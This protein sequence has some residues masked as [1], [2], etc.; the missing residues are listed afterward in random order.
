MRPE[1][2]LLC[3]SDG[4]MRRALALPFS[5]FLA[6]LSLPGCGS[7]SATSVNV[8]G[9]SNSRCQASVSAQPSTFAPAG[10]TGE[11]TVTV[12]RECTWTAASNAGWIE[13]TA[14]REGQGEGTVRYRIAENGEPVTRRG[15]LVVAEQ[16]VQVAQEPAP[17]RFDVSPRETRTGADGGEVSVS[18][19]THSAC[20]WRVS[21][22]SAWASASPQSGSGN[23]TVDI[24]LPA[25]D[26]ASSRS[27]VVTIAGE[28]VT[29]VQ[30]GRGSAPP[31]A[32]P[33]PAP[34]APTPPP[35]SPP[36][37]EPPPVP[38]PAP[39]PP[40]APE[41]PPTACEYEFASPGAAFEAQGGTGAVRLRTTAAC[42]WTAQS[43]AAWV[44]ITSAPSGTGSSEIRYTV[45]E[46]FTTSPRVATI[47]IRS[48][49]Y[50][51]V[52]D[53]AREVRISG[54]I[55]ALSGSCPAI[56]F[57][58]GDTIVTTNG[59][60]NFDDGRCVDAR[61]GDLVDVRGYR[62]PNGTVLARRVEF[63]D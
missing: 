63:E 56:R 62:Q 39:P 5:A 61:I 40:P 28:R 1:R 25:H 18:V 41:P 17:C 24:R 43:S 12:G 54:Q 23:A 38:P 7:S 2:H 32:P 9:P 21:S 33:A 26:G 29:V 50:R 8:T 48:A 59:E 53:R 3:I 6:L 52:Q 22:G 37:P 36:A 11:V 16:T 30:D 14:G 58:V 13:L 46:N 34:P 49:V 4:R 35:P 55:S 60:T 15:A 57:T 42:A 20:T 19:R 45:A 51:I 47:T 27:T 31:P 10:G 44:Q